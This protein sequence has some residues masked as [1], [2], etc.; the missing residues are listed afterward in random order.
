MIKFKNKCWF[1]VLINIDL[2]Y[3]PMNLMD[4][5]YYESV[6]HVD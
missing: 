1:W 4:K 3:N 6:N 5:S 2:N